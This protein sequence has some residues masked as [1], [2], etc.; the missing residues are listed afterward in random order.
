MS[1]ELQTA[2]QF[3]ATISF[4]AETDELPAVSVLVPAWNEAPRI[5]A[6]IES[7]LAIDWPRLEILVSAGGNDGTYEVAKRYA[8]DRVR[9]IE[10]RPGEG[11]QAA[12]R[13][14]L[15]LAIGDVVYLSDGDSVIP[16]PTF[17]AVLEPIVK[18]EAEVVTGPYRPYQHDAAAPFVFYQWSIDRAVE[19]RREMHSEGVSGANVAL[20]RRAL[21]AI[22]GFNHE[23]K[24]GTDYHLARRLRAAGFAIRYVD[25]AVETE[26]AGSARPLVHRRSRWLRNIVLHGV[27]FDDYQAIFA[28][29]RTVAVSAG[30]LLWPLGWRWTRL[31][32]VLLWF[33][34]FSYLLAV[35]IRYAR[36]LSAETGLPAGPGYLARLPWYTLLDVTASLWPLLDLASRGRRWRW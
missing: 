16:A 31:P 20:T 10:Q 12:L 28:T 36:R 22:D 18:G 11:K 14:L 24:T 8:S 19:R 6:C 15:T 35:R 9:V 32:G 4:P 3:A 21:D 26:Y 29:A 5:G 1:Q 30:F 34:A 27:A 7:L 25:S 13:S 23:V 2:Q 17:H 33:T